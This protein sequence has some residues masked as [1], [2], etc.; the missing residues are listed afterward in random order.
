MRRLIPVLLLVSLLTA[1]GGQGPQATPSATP[2]PTPAPTATPAP[3]AA[4]PPILD[5]MADQPV[6]DFLDAEQQDLFLRA[7]SAANF[8][9]GCSTSSVDEYPLADG[10]LP[11]R[12]DY[13][14]VTLDN[15]W[16]YLVAQGRYAQWADFQAM[17]D[18]V[19]TPE[20]QEELL[21]TESLD[22]ERFPTFTSTEDG[23][24]CFL[25]AGR[26]SSLEYGWADTP[27]TY[28]LVSRSEDVV[29]FDLIGHYAVLEDDTG[30]E[31][32]V[33]GITTERYPIRMERTAAGWRI[34]EFHL[35]Y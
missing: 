34:A 10:T 14:T 18:S 24:L 11:E 29:E 5:W 35:P 20:Y 26:G 7:F 30:D 8:L 28:E 23:R 12:G 13:E 15:G 9:I 31:P 17:L 19:F 2:A 3:Q 4:E 33:S 22:G 32:T 1:C 6:P 25:D 16:T 21:W 27:D